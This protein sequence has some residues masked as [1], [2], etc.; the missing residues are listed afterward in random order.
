MAQESIGYQNVALGYAQLAESNRHN[1]AQERINKQNADTNYANALWN[2]VDRQYATDM[3]TASN[4]KIA[5]QNRASNM[6]IAKANNETRTYIASL[7]SGGNLIGRLV[8]IF[9]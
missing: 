6:E 5:S 7:E 8:D 2:T 9:T 4:E 1:V 3:Q